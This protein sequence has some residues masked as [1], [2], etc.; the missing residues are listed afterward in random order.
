VNGSYSDIARHLTQ[1]FALDPPLD[2][3]RVYAWVRQ[4][5]LNADDQPVPQPVRTRRKVLRTHP[6]RLWDLDA[7]ADWYRP[8]VRKRGRP[9]K[10]VP[11][12]NS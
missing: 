5:S 2:R 4:G 12:N 6:T 11:R 7:F 9:A 10:V 1:T 3:R 8:G